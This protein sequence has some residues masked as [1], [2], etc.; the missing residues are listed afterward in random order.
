M[1][2]SL[3]KPA[4]LGVG[5]AVAVVTMTW[6]L[7]RRNAS[8]K[9]V[10]VDKLQQLHRGTVTVGPHTLRD[11][12]VQGALFDCDGTLIDSMAAWL[13]S[14]KRSCEEFGLAITEEQ[15]WG[16]AGVPLPDIVISLYKDKHGS[17]PSDDFVREFLAFKRQ[18][19]DKSEAREGSPPAI[20]VVVNIARQF[21][22]MGIPIAVATSGLREIVERHL[23]HA[24][25]TE[26]FPIVVCAAEVPR[27]KPAPDIFL[28]A[29][30]KIGVDP[31]K[32]RAYEDGESGL[33]AA[34]KAGCHVL[35]V[36]EMPG[37][38]ASDGLIKGMA[39]QRASRRWLG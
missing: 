23:N 34:F 19:H 9:R 4:V 6:V 3:G 36:R 1:E 39:V 38:P 10:G 14:W 16:F 18:T 26:L 2:L 11:D 8:R 22:D 13:P 28:R 35:D 29:A 25:L 7:S 32:C 37:Y 24:G 12:E 17:A 30:E 21:R 15:F 20:D 5:L 31:T 27:G 33:E